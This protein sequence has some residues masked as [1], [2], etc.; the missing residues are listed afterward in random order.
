ML[1]ENARI[2]LNI[3]KEVKED[4]EYNSNMKDQPKKDKLKYTWMGKGG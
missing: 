1:Q 4:D 2:I 3:I